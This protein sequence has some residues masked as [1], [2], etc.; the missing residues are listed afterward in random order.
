MMP[1][2]AEFASG[3]VAALLAQTCVAW[4]AP[5]PWLDFFLVLALVLGFRGA[6]ADARIAGWLVGLVQDLGSRDP[7]GIHALSLGLA[8]YLLTRLREF[9]PV[10][11]F[12]GRFVLMLLS[13]LS[14]QIVY[15]AHAWFW[16]TRPGETLAELVFGAIAS[17]LAAALLSAWFTSA[18]IGQS[19][20]RSR[21]AARRSRF[22]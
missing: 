9:S 22:S 4:F 19:R 5:A 20:R 18:S 11:P 12:A 14:A 6:A 15:V 16:S 21:W 2:W 10:E 13:A 7:L 8:V 1:F 17:A 3:V